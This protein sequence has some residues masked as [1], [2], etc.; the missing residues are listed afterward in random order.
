MA[1]G[2]LAAIP[3]VITA[4]ILWYV[5]TKA[6]ALFGAEYP[7]LGIGITLVLIYL[8]GLFVSSVLGKFVIGLADG[9]LRRIPGLQRAL[10]SRG[11]RSRSRPAATRGSSRT[12]C[13]SPTRAG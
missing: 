13:W 12:S 9:L 8:L 6:R 2:A 7:G 10:L 1:A 4:F 5:D 3:V 11:S